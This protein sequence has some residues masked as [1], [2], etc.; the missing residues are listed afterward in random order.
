MRLHGCADGQCM[1][2]APQPNPGGGG[3]WLQVQ[4][5]CVAPCASPLQWYRLSYL[6]SSAR[7][8]GSFDII[9]AHL[10]C[11]PDPCYCAV[12]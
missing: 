8:K 9:M 10:R 3:S 1:S 5:R 4:T 2:E 11:G 7:T 12:D 6:T